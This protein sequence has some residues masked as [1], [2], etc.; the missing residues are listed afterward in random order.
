MNA[1]VTTRPGAL[2]LEAAAQFVALSPANVQKLVREGSFPK[3]RQLSARRVGYLVSELEAWL[4]GRP[5]SDL[6]PPPDSGYGSAGKA[7]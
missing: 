3:P 2:D 6:P 5:V 1:V 4:V 7:A